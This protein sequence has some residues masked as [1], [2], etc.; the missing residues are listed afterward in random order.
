[1]NYAIYLR[2]SRADLE[3][4][5]EMDTLIKHE[6]TLLE[7]A[8]KK[9]LT[10]SST[11]KEV[12]S[13][14][15]IAS[16]PQMQNLLRDV[17][18][19]LY[20]GVLVMEVERLA[21]GDTIDQGIVAQ[22]FKLSNTKIITPTKTYDPNNEYDE[23]YFE[24]GLFM[25]RREYKTIKR[26]LNAGRL[27]SVADGN[28]VG[29][30]APY[31][32]N[33]IR[34]D[35]NWT[36][37]INENESEVV[38][39]IYQFYIEGKSKNEIARQLNSL[40]YKTRNDKKWTVNTIKDILI[41]PVY[42]G[43]IKWDS[44]KT[45]KS[46][47][48][49]RIKI[50]RPRSTEFKVYN[51]IHESIIDIFTWNRAQELNKQNLP[52]TTDTSLKNPLSGIIICEKCGR[53]MQRRPYNKRGQSPTLICTNTECDNISAPLHI[54]EEKILDALDEIYQNYRYQKVKKEN[55]KIISLKEQYAKQLEKEQA[56]LERVYQAYEDGTYD[57]EEFINRKKII[58]DKIFEL[59]SHLKEDKQSLTKKE[60]MH[61]MNSI[62]NAYKN[63]D[64]EEQNELLKT[65]IE[66][67]TYLKKVKCVKKDSNPYD[68]E[69]TLYLKYKG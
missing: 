50:S 11:Y 48:N 22:T 63:A 28:Y 21:R 8:N 27:R 5:N 19:G 38:K 10:I 66:K 55:K 15:T 52:K 29:S 65:V 47:V 45:V 34:I 58:D 68:F 30:I 61:R 24:F 67:I 69:L 6:K 51:G 14:D 35:K 9:G 26:R 62:L 37:A 41:N 3:Y 17:E 7:L 54:V 1:M 53:Y 40:G 32:Y 31:G 4:E 25:S 2:K 44:R 59:K 57:K 23:E 16:R 12:V 46:V 18:E 43:K 33:R 49:G 56:K 60:F 42:I 39:L 64:V 36:L 13:G 20:D